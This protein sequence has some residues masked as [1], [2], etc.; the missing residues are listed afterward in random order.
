MCI[1]SIVDGFHCIY[2]LYIYSIADGFYC[3]Y[4]YI[5]IYIFIYTKIVDDFNVDV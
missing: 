2:I 1:Y 3:T 4:I 5:Y